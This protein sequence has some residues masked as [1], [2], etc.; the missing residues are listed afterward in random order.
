MSYFKYNE[1]LHRIC[2]VMLLEMVSQMRIRLYYE[3]MPVIESDVFRFL[4]CLSFLYSSEKQ[5]F[6]NTF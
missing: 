4:P 5:N 2:I 3:Y 1:V 6:S